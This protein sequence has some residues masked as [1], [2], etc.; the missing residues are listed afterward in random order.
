MWSKG[1]AMEWYVWVLIG[2]AAIAIAYIKLKLLGKLM[3]RRQ[4]TETGEAED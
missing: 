3:K 4:E 2:V 1:E